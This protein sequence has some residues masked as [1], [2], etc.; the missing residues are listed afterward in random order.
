MRIGSYEV[1]REL[2]QGGMGVVYAVRSE[3]LPGLRALK[4]LRNVADPAAVLRFR[5]EAELL[6]RVRHRGIVTIHEVGECEA[7]FYLVMDL[8]EGE[9]LNEVLRRGAVQPAR[10]RGWIL[11]LADAVAALHA[12]GILH[13]DLKPSNL[14]LRPDG[15]LLLLDFGLA[16]TAG[17]S[18]LT[19]TG[20]I[21]G[22]PGFMA[23]EQAEG[24]SE[25]GPPVDVHG[26]GAILY[27]L[28]S[29]VA[30]YEGSSV[31]EGLQK[32]LNETVE[33][34]PDLPPDLARVGAKALAKD[35]AQRYPDA[36]AFAAAIRAAAEAPLVTSSRVWLVALVLSLGVV[37]VGAA[38]VLSS[39]SPGV[40]NPSP[41]SA[42]LPSQ[43]ATPAESPVDWSEVP[44]DLERR[45]I[46]YRRFW[47]EAR[48]R[49]L[50]A[51]E[52]KTLR[53]VQSERLRDLSVDVGEAPEVRFW[54]SEHWVRH[55]RKGLEWGRWDAPTAS[56]RRQDLPPGLA[57]SQGQVLWSFHYRGWKVF[58]SPS[59]EEPLALLPLPLPKEASSEI[60]P[61][62]LVTIAEREGRLALA[63]QSSVWEWSYPKG[64]LKL[65]LSRSANEIT[66]VGYTRGGVLLARCK[67]GSATRIYSPSLP[68]LEGFHGQQ[69][70][71]AMAFHPAR[72][73]L[74]IGDNGGNLMLWAPGEREATSIWQT[75]DP[76]LEIKGVAFGPRGDLIY[77]ACI[78][79]KRGTGELRVFRQSE[80]GWEE[81]RIQRLAWAP[82]SVRVSSEGAWLL[83]SGHQ[84]HG[85]LWPAG[86]RGY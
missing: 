79:E 28:L 24:R 82:L 75:S 18:S 2:G 67:A 71:D 78:K 77:A 39:L 62:H 80:R 1:V 52:R 19:N 72:E 60:G 41:S 81:S 51:R 17:R 29:G 11:E 34:S 37:L 27:A 5:R 32:V 12:R 9:P 3:S 74:A 22:S 50:S 25:L 8:V 66:E 40:V 54:G 15:S 68:L 6:A 38:W 44:R 4:L 33:W 63:T 16:R 48:T 23:P 43:P 47:L 20:A 26:L 42:T 84:G 53:R 45:A 76:F 46:W 58:R 21:A 83:L 86:D 61:R 10:A 69:R 59:P 70:A 85:E 56:P 65:L 57:E 7:G 49:E 14:M 64:P 31:F 35:P 55:R 73:L 36:A 30:P 13:R